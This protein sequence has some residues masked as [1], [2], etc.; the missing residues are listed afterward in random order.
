MEPN[1]LPAYL[2]ARLDNT[3]CEGANLIDLN[4]NNLIDEL[5]VSGENGTSYNTWATTT[6]ST[7]D[8]N[9][10]ACVYSLEQ[11]TRF[12][13][14]FIHFFLDS[15]EQ[16]IPGSYVIKDSG[17]DGE[18]GIMVEYFDSAVAEN[19]FLITTADETT[20]F[21]ITGVDGARIC[22]SYRL[23][24]PTVEEYMEAEFIITLDNVE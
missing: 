18:P 8:Q 10:I 12:L 9:Y 22:G 16:I 19:A 17:A 13:S 4:I 11:D 24:I 23:Y 3:G 1:A 21:L 15:K 2:E 20:Y 6:Y 14:V 5:I 7:G